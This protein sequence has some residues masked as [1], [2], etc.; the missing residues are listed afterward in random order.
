VPLDTLSFILG[1]I[2]VAAAL[3]GGGLEIKELRLPQIGPIAR[4][5]SA[6]VGIGFVGLALYVHAGG[7]GP[8]APAP[9]PEPEKAQLAFQS[10]MQDG[11][12]LDVCLQ[13]AQ[14][15]GE[16][17]ASGWCKTKGL[18]RAIDY[19]EENVGKQGIAT[20]TLA[21]NE[22]CKADFCTSFVYITC[23]K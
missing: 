6:A 3:F 16:P 17:A 21:S 8:I 22:V 18:T 15:C 13:F 1:G 2:L 5:L 9:N 12:R 11:L 19:P 4:V 10:P 7:A 20:R 14:N 23:E